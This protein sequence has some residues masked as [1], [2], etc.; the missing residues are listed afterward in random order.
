MFVVGK[1]TAL[2]YF[3]ELIGWCLYGVTLLWTGI[4]VLAAYGSPLAIA[5]MIGIILLVAAIKAIYRSGDKEGL[6][7]HF[8]EKKYQAALNEYV[9]IGK[10]KQKSGDELISK[11]GDK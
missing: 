9:R 3:F 5:W 1:H 8:D 11:G 7:D 2:S 10:A 6:D 4:L